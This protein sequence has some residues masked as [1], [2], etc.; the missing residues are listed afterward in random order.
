MNN[1]ALSW[2]L[3]AGVVAIGIY[4]GLNPAMGWP[5]AV[6]RGLDQKRGAAVFGS[7]MP[8]GAGHL[9]A[10]AMVLVPFA[11]LAWLLQWSREI[12]IAVGALVLLFGIAQL[13]LPQRHR[14]L[15]RIKPTQLALWSFLMATA[16]GAALMLLPILMGLC[17][18][19]AATASL[20]DHAGMADLM[21]T[22]LGTAVIVSLVHTVAMIGSGLSAAWIVYRY[23]GLRAL[24]TAW[25][26]LEKVW[27]LGLI[28][29]G[30]AAVMTALAMTGA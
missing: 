25:L 16:H 19:P 12:R 22:S 9:L 20:V 30:G 10:M 21:R 13:V 5:L 3:W 7:W 4:H 18:A 24:R 2:P 8:L 23:L 27:A 14:R 1:L 11:V 17:D 6:A 28:A 29:S 15:A 26:N